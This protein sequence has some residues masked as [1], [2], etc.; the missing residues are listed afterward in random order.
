[1]SGNSSQ[2]R[3]QDLGR[4][5]FAGQRMARPTDVA[6]D[7]SAKARASRHGHRSVA[8]DYRRHSPSTRTNCASFASHSRAAFSAT[9]IQHW[10]EIG[11]RAR[12]DA[13]DLARRGL[14]LQIVSSR[15]SQFLEQPYVLDCDDRLIGEGFTNSI[16]LL[17]ERPR[18]RPIERDNAPVTHLPGASARQD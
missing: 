13:Q 14:L 4:G 6:R 18:L 5:S 17:G 16:C 8:C 2:P 15:L 12:D 10:L 3:L 7:G 1:M 9:D 11:G